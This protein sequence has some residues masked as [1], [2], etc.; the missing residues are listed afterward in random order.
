MILFSAI[1]QMRQAFSYFDKQDKRIKDE[2]RAEDGVEEDMEDLKQVTVKFARADNDKLK[3]AREK[4][5][6]YISQLGADEPWCETLWVPNKSHESEMEKQKLFYSSHSYSY[7]GGNDLN[8]TSTE[9]LEE[10][11]T[12]KHVVCDSATAS[13]SSTTASTSTTPSNTNSASDTATETDP[14][15]SKKVIGMS[16]LKKLP[17]IDQIKLLLRDGE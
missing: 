10:L 5:Y 16:K 13:S 4:S 7:E 17:L 8:L 1:L 2:K 12:E 3:K 6:N 15:L 11:L 9:Y 14:L